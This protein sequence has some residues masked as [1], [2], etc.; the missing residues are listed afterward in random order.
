M[1]KVN[2]VA[3]RYEILKAMHKLVCSMNDESAYY[4]WIN[5]VP[6][7]ASRE[8]LWEVAEDVELFKD[9]CELFRWIMKYYGASGFFIKFEN[10][11]F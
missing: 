7:E 9:S 1:T 5:L 6:D 11:V 2:N 4:E 8:D 3:E 10:S